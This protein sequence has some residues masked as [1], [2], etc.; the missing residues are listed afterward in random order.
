MSSLK[1]EL[2][3]YCWLKSYWTTRVIRIH[4]LKNVVTCAC[5]HHAQSCIIIY[6]NNNNDN[7]WDCKQ[8]IGFKKFRKWQHF[9]MI[10]YYSLAVYPVLNVSFHTVCSAPQDELLHHRPGQQQL[11]W[12]YRISWSCDIHYSQ[13]YALGR[14]TNKFSISVLVPVTK[15][16]KS[17]SLSSISFWLGSS[18]HSIFPTDQ[19][20]LLTLMWT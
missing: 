11:L 15:C 1:I 14:L 8:K 4:V 6:N 17:Y 12:L 9:A 19:N 20:H 3:L 5:A 7:K 10:I 2:V 16:S 18:S 13:T